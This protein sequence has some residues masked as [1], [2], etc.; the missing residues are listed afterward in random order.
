M[1]KGRPITVEWQD[2]EQELYERYQAETDIHRRQKAQFLWLVKSGKTIRESCRIA[3][4]QERAGQR[5]MQWYRAGGLEYVLS[6]QH[7]GN[8]GHQHSLLDNEQQKQLKAAADAG[9]LKTIWEGIAWVK[10]KF[11]VQYS[12]EGMRSVF[13]RLRLRKKVPRKQHIKSDKQAQTAWKKGGLP[14]V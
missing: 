13:K 9:E 7:G 4:L 3:A 11:N 10:Q 6:R 1:T 12:Y 5:Y 14:T 2:S 8:N